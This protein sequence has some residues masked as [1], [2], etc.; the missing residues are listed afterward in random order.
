MCHVV[1]LLVFTRSNFHLCHN[2][3]MAYFFDLLD[4]PTRVKVPCD[5]NVSFYFPFFQAVVAINFLYSDRNLSTSPNGK[6]AQLSL[7]YVELALD[8]V[9]PFMIMNVSKPYE[10]ITW[11]FCCNRIFFFY[12]RK[13]MF[14]VCS[15]S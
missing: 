9:V 13:W 12:N 10:T 11:S 15:F 4:L 6:I 8:L 1:A 14:S 2:V 7:C 5:K 3:V